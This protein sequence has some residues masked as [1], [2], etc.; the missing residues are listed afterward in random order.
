GSVPIFIGGEGPGALVAH[1][2]R[3]QVNENAERP[4][5]AAVVPETGHNEIVGWGGGPP[6]HR[7]AVELRCQSDAP[8]IQRRFDAMAGLLDG[9][10]PVVHRVDLDG[11]SLVATLA[12]GVLWVDLLSVHLALQ[13]GVDPTPVARLVTLKQRLAGP[14]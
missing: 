1:R 14:A 8:A 2:A 13:S 3:C 10:V 5:I 4:A 12:A 9:I 7:A 11:P 6:V